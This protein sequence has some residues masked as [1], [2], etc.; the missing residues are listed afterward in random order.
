MGGS[1][2]KRGGEAQ[3]GGGVIAPVRTS[4][5]G[6][7]AAPPSFLLR[8]KSGDEHKELFNSISDEI[9]GEKAWMT[10]LTLR[11]LDAGQHITIRA[12]SRDSLSGWP[13][14]A[15]SGQ[16]E[17]FVTI[18]TAADGDNGGGEG[19][20][21]GHGQAEDWA[22][23]V[24]GKKRGT[25]RS[26][27]G[28]G[29]SGTGG[30]D[31]SRAG[32]GG[33]GDGGGDGGGSSRGGGGGRGSPHASGNGGGGP[34]PGG[35]LGGS[36]VPPK[37]SD[38]DALLEMQAEEEKVQAEA[39]I[40]RGSNDWI[41]E[42]WAPRAAD[43]SSGD[44]FDSET[45]YQKRFDREWDEQLELLQDIPGAAGGVQGIMWEYDD[46]LINIFDYYASL[47]CD[48][49][50]SSMTFNEWGQF[51]DD[52]GIADNKS[53]GSKKADLDRVFIAVDTKA[54]HLAKAAAA[55]RAEAGHKAEAST[56]ELKALRRTEFFSA[57][58]MIS[59][60]KY[61]RSGAT[62][63]LA[64]GMQK[65]MDDVILPSINYDVLPDPNTFRKTCY[66]K[67]VS[68]ELATNAASLRALHSKL[69][70]VE[71]GKQ[72]LAN[73]RIGIRTWIT[74]A[75]AMDFVGID[76]TIRECE[77]CFVWS[78]MS[79]SGPPSAKDDL[80]SF[81]GFLE[82]LC[83]LASIKALPTDIEV[84]EKGCADAGQYVLL[85]NSTDETQREFEQMLKGRRVGWG[86]TP[87]QTL[88]RCVAHV[89]SIMIRSIE[90]ASP[91][92]S[93]DG[94]NELSDKEISTWMKSRFKYDG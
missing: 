12:D 1:R 17:L 75:R 82:A 35:E 25:S 59:L 7:S 14:W 57:L 11:R 94:N 72:S 68:S 87:A 6:S 58:I 51:I 40:A 62:A 29:G 32:D 2:V 46:V 5:D 33:D 80:L 54:D 43:A 79:A 71:F 4:I 41:G 64:E 9:N 21:E 31:G 66:V 20:R 16:F 38:L 61:V 27:A 36:G 56:D 39:S 55:A 47:N 76:L 86:G 91:Q 34:K 3:S 60:V 42:I 74:F 52:F 69:G 73:T 24:G 67:S 53:D 49:R 89:I 93:A 15:E 30:G 26:R 22:L 23:A 85:M 37:L 19:K 18:Q 65:L 77:L 28:G 50:I 70:E 10:E 48:G 83:R 78:R 44:F 88:D 8:L 63:T 13:E 45:V 84:E 81:E 92:A 90:A